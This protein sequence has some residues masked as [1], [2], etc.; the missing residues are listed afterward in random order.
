M[1][2]TSKS[3]FYISNILEFKDFLNQKYLHSLA[4]LLKPC[5]DEGAVLCCLDDGD[6]VCDVLH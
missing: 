6:A 1:D 3:S 4:R 2:L 5:L